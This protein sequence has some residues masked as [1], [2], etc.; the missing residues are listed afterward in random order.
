[1]SDTDPVMAHDPLADVAERLEQAPPPPL[2]EDAASAMAGA[3]GET[4]PSPVSEA[5]DGTAFVLPERLGIQEVGELHGVL[6][7]MLD[8]GGEIRLDAGSIDSIDGAGVQLLAV[9]FK[10]AV[11][12]GIGVGWSAVSPA[13]ADAAGILGL[14]ELLNIE[15]TATEAEQQ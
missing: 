14:R 6:R 7:D 15:P 3:A 4:A 8:A 13:L 2:E 1:M 12:H 10:E 11:T 5:D 9:F